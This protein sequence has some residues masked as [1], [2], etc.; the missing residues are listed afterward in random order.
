MVILYSFFDFAV[1]REIPHYTVAQIFKNDFQKFPPENFSQNSFCI[2][3]AVLTKFC[4]YYK[5]S[6]LRKYFKGAPAAQPAAAAPKQPAAEEKDD[7]F[8]LFGSED[9]EEDEEKKKVVEE[10]LKAYAAK[11][12]AKV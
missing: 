1:K 3:V 2:F 10:R 12:S 6:K 11:K 4:E 9:E 8:D 5:L 7:D